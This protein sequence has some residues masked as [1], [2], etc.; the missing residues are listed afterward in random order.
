MLLA[1]PRFKGF[2]PNTGALVAAGKVYS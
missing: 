1:Y 2:D